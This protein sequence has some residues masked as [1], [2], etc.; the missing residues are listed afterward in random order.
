MENIFK[1]FEGKLVR[2]EF[3]NALGNIMEREGY[4]ETE[5]K[6]AYLYDKG[7]G[8]NNYNCALNTSKN[9]VVSITEINEVYIIPD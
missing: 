1:R 6:W 5:D 3:V 8:G 2:V 4:L 9:N 7:K